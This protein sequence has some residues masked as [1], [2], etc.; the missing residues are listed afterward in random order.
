MSV[1]P[2]FLSDGN[3]QL[4]VWR[5]GSDVELLVLPGLCQGSAPRARQLSAA[6]P[7]LG[8]VAVDMMSAFSVGGDVPAVA[9][10][11]AGAM[12]QIGSPRAVVGFD[13]TVPLADAVRAALGDEELPLFAMHSKRMEDAGSLERLLPAADGTHLLSLWHHL[14]AASMMEEKGIRARQSGEPYATTEELHDS[15]LEFGEQPFRYLEAWEKLRAWRAEG[16][17]IRRGQEEVET[18]E[19]LA[20]RIASVVPPRT[21]LPPAP[22]S[23]KPALSSQWREYIETPSGHF[24]VRRYGRHGPPVILLQS[25]PGSAAPL[26]AIGEYFGR[27]FQVWCPDFLGNGESSKPDRTPDIAQLAAEIVELADAAGLTRFHLFGTHTGAKVALAVASLVAARVGKII[28]DGLSLMEPALRSDVL[29]HYLPPLIPSPWGTHLHQAWNMRRDMFLFWPW[30]RQSPESSR[31]MGVPS[32]QDLHDWTVG[33]LQ[34]GRTY[35]QSYRAAFM[36]DARALLPNIQ[37]PVLLAV[38]PHDMFANDLDQARKLMPGPVEVFRAGATAWYPG[39]PESAV[40]ST[41]EAFTRFLAAEPEGE[42]CG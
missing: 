8:V 29:Q 35:D 7:S 4:R 19:A 38:G 33:L 25:A 24:H 1:R 36:C 15:L 37:H 10:R 40:V 30:Y 21:G 22:P 3:N 6:M 2:Q 18:Y 16:R 17:V 41:L 23:P 20:A 39:Q 11:I 32:T 28:L 13:L 42:P 27:Q 12:R 14:R 31:A 5:S 26:N 34:S 9:A